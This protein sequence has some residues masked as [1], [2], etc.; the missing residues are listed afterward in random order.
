MGLGD[1]QTERTIFRITSEYT[2]ARTMAVV[3]GGVCGGNN[4]VDVVVKRWR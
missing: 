4:T 1:E 2:K 3:G